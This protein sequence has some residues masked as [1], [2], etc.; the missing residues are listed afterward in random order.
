MP[1]VFLSSIR[2]IADRSQLQRIPHNYYCYNAWCCS[3]F[4][5]LN[6][7]K[8]KLNLCLL[9]RTNESK[10]ERKKNI[11]NKKFDDAFASSVSEDSCQFYTNE[12]PHM[13][14]AVNR[15]LYVGVNTVF[16]HDAGK[17]FVFSF[18]I[19]GCICCLFVPL[20][21]TSVRWSLTNIKWQIGSSEIGW[22]CSP[23]CWWI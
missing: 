9:K 16:N 23:Y 5:M 19:S 21:D 12:A 14:I 11:V 4:C 15:Q 7:M 1:Y 2:A 13:F 6:G 20:E 3:G 22:W 10:I 18:L 8:F 17:F